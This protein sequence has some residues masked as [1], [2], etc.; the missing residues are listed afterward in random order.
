MHTFPVVGTKL[1]LRI[2][3][4][5]SCYCLA[6]SI[7]AIAPDFSICA[8][9]YTKGDTSPFSGIVKDHSVYFTFLLLLNS[10]NRQEFTLLS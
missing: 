9:L 2:H 7:T 6:I 8:E 10:S 1:E 5:L 3:L 4:H